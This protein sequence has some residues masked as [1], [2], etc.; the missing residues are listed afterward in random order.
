MYYQLD[1]DYI[2]GL[3]LVFIV[4]II[5]VVVNWFFLGGKEKYEWIDN[6]RK[7]ICG[8]RLIVQIENSSEY[9]CMANDGTV[10]VIRECEYQK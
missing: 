8:D 5:A 9:Q 6:C 7:E 1:K 3:I 4:F 2:G 10:Q